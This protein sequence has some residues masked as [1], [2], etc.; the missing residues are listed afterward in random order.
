M[1]LTVADIIY[2]AYRIAGILREAGRGASPSAKADGLKV[3]NAM[4][5]S[6]KAERLMVYAILRTPLSLQA[7]KATYTIGTSGSPDFTLERP[8]KITNAG[9]ILTDTE[10]ALEILTPQ[11][12]AALSPKTLSSSIPYKL[13]YEPLVPNG[14]ITLWPTPTTA[15]Q[16]ALYT[17]QTVNQFA[18]DTD[19]VIIAP[20]Y[21][22]ALEYQLAIR[23]AARFPERASLSPL[24]LEFAR[25]A[26]ARVKTINF[27]ELQM[28]VESATRG[29]IAGTAGHYNILSNRTF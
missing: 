28:Q 14:K 29:R 24:S 9:L 8:E 1:P 7:N 27:P 21:Q 6:W 5:D 12:W 26:L 2:S 15:W 19:Q 17:W 22:E 16:L 25:N 10:N 23:L 11:T 4:I 3:L 20:A 13:Y 18:A